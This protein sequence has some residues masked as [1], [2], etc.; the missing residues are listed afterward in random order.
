LKAHYTKVGA[1]SFINSVPLIAGL[2]KNPSVKLIKAVPSGLLTMLEQQKA[3]VALIPSIDYQF[4]RGDLRIIRCGAI[5][6]RGQ[7]LTVRIFSRRPVDTIKTLACDTDSHTSV[8]LAR[9]VLKEMYNIE[10][11]V[12]RLDVAKDPL[13]ADAD[14]LLVIGDKVINGVID[15]AFKAYELDLAEA[16]HSM[17]GFGFVF[18]VWACRPGFDAEEIAGILKRTLDV[19]LR[20][21]DQLTK[22]HAPLHNWPETTAKQYL[23]K[24]MYYRLDSSQ[25]KGLRAFYHLAHAQGLVRR[26]KMIRFAD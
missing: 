5:G 13:T 2:E 23:G 18:A 9:V 22:E 20:R 26:H 21:I 10:P 4:A 17:T 3:D 24:Y 6:A 1:V 15:P 16:W 19:N 25:I 8:I 12:N 7:S 14:A 11:E